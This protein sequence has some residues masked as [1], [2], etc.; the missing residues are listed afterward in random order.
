[1]DCNIHLTLSEDE[2]R[3]TLSALQRELNY[4]HVTGVVGRYQTVHDLLLGVRERLCQALRDLPAD[5]R[6]GEV[7]E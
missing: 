1:M 5:D 6:D 2:A 3:Q 4:F 7:Y